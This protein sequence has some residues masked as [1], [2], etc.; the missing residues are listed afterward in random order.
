MTMATTTAAIAASKTATNSG[1][2]LGFFFSVPGSVVVSAGRLEGL[3]EEG[4]EEESGGAG[5]PLEEVSELS[6]PEP[7]EEEPSEEI[8]LLPGEVTV[9]PPPAVP[10]SP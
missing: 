9:P 1:G 3:T 7:D 6:L 8:P 4:G 10:A 5:S 2:L